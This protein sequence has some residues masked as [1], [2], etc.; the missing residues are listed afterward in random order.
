LA[1]SNASASLARAL[2]LAEITQAAQ[3]I[4]EVTVQNVQPYWAAPAGRKAIR[5]RVSFQVLQSVKGNPGSSFTLDFLGGEVD[6]QGLKVPDVPQFAPGE[7]YILFC[8]APGKALVCPVLGLT[9]G[10]LRVLH[11]NEGDVDRVFRHWGQPVNQNE[12][13]DT[14]VPVIPGATT[15]DYLRSA[16]TVEQFLARVRQEAAKQ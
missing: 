8:A 14:K 11:D 16:D 10:A 7:R 12:R 4:A 13:F 2:S 3:I 15:R 9:Q 5:T 1:G 6:G